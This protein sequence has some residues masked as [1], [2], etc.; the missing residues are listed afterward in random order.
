MAAG[1]TRWLAEAT[2]TKLARQM[3]TCCVRHVVGLSNRWVSARCGLS[4]DG[5]SLARS[6]FEILTFMMIVVCCVL[7]G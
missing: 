5:V 1:A 2:A 4:F 3:M 6:A 7:F